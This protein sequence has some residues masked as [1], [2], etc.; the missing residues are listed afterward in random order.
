MMRSFSL[1]EALRW[2]QAQSATNNLER[3][4]VEG[5]STDTRSLEKGQLF[6]ALRGEHFDGHRFL[7][8]ALERGACGAV[9]DSLRRPQLMRASGRSKR[10]NNG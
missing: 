2:T 3:Y 1:A 10:S 7:G 5:V 4:R 9:V 6:V 8:A